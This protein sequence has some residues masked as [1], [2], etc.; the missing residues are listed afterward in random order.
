MGNLLGE[1]K[2]QVLIQQLRLNEKTAS[3]LKACRKAKLELLNPLVVIA[4]EP[5]RSNKVMPPPVQ[6]SGLRAG[7]AA[8]AK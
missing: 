6:A 2:R 5:S 4:I 3:L 7:V 1:S 8:S